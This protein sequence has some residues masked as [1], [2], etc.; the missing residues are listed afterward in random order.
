MFLPQEKQLI[1]WLYFAFKHTLSGKL[2]L[3]CQ[4]KIPF[5][6]SKY[7]LKEAMALNISKCLYSHPYFFF[8]TVFMKYL[9][10]FFY[11]KPMHVLHLKWVFYRQHI[12]EYCFWIYSANPCVLIGEVNLF[13]FKRIIGMNLLLPLSFVFCV[14]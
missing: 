13:T 2:P 14:F 7:N 11:F 8:I 12:L 9:F 5:Y 1:D 3:L 10:P 6:K 4:M